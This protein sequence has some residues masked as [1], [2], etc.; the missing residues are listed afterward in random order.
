MQSERNWGVEKIRF[1][2][3]E[4]NTKL[5]SD[6]VKLQNGLAL[7]EEA[8]KET[9]TAHKSIS[10]WVWLGEGRSEGL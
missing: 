3:R 8:G 5:L 7:W 1:L 9:D 4:R 6:F 2:E 10:R